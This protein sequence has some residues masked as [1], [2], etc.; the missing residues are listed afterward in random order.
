[1]VA[2]VG[3]CTAQQ[4]VDLAHTEII[5]QLTILRKASNCDTKRIIYVNVAVIYTNI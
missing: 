4:A 3:G 1:M 5:I 2:G